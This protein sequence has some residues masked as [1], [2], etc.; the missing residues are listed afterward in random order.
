MEEIF[1]GKFS[2]SFELIRF[3][4]LVVLKKNTLSRLKEH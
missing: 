2:F 4:E 3:G 1:C